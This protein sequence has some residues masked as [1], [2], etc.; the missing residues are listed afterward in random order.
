MPRQRL[1]GRTSLGQRI[2][3]KLVRPLQI[4]RAPKFLGGKTRR[5][6][7]KSRSRSRR[8]LRNSQKPQRPHYGDVGL[9]KDRV[10]YAKLANLRSLPATLRRAEAPETYASV[11][12]QHKCHWSKRSQ[13]TPLLPNASTPTTLRAGPGQTQGPK[14]W[15]WTRDK[16][17]R[18][19]RSAAAVS[20]LLAVSV[21]IQVRLAGSAVAGSASAPLVAM[22]FRPTY[23]PVSKLTAQY[24]QILRSR[25]AKQTCPRKTT[26][27]GAV[28]GWGRNY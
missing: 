5:S 17:A 12:R 20:L 3:L 1:A 6:R 18:R 21:S 13:A 25:A 16:P 10:V 24:A 15:L 4:G 8:S 28:A 11:A 14:R 23:F 27:P 22:N 26:W 7:P 19:A 9:S 2:H